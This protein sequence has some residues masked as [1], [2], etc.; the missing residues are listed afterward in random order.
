MNCHRPPLNRVTINGRTYCG[1]C[2]TELTFEDLRQVSNARVSKQGI[3]SQWNNVP[4][5]R[6]NNSWEKGNRFD[7]R[8]IPY[9][10][11][12][13]LPLKVKEPFKRTDYE[14]RIEIS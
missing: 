9:L 8:G 3:P 2:R 6:P 5:P 11:K 12:K 14:N 10:D 7:D 13:G 1:K 4:P